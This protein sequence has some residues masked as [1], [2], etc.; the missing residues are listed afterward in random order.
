MKVKTVISVATIYA[1][2]AIALAFYL[3]YVLLQT[4]TVVGA[5]MPLFGAAVFL[6]PVIWAGPL[7]SVVL[8]FIFGF[9]ASIILTLIP[10]VVGWKRSIAAKGLSILMWTALWVA[11]GFAGTYMLDRTSS[12]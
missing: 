4:D 7:N 1:L 6:L 12:V 8:S 5:A 3:N 9:I 11:T 10:L 2:L